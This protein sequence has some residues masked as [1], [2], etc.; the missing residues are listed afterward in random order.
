[1][2]RSATHRNTSAS[3]TSQTV[4]D[5]ADQDSRVL[6]R[7]VDDRQLAGD[8]PEVARWLREA[9]FTVETELV[10]RPDEEVPGA[11]IVARGPDV[12]L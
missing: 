2:A 9:G 7:L 4:R 11:L 6:L 5:D 8:H 12:H 10:M 3:L 1:M